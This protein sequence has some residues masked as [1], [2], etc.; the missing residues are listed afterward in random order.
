M[1]S[2]ITDPLSARPSPEE[3]AELQAAIPAEVRF[4]TST[5]TYPGW[6]GL[7]YSRPYPETGAAARMLAEYARWPL[8]GTVGIDS[9]FYGPPKPATL[10]AWAKALTPGFPC[11]SKV[12]DRITVHTFSGERDRTKSG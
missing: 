10:T 12:W 6:Y 3:L 2:R 4:G 1:E 8:F 7:V 11:V 5:W 9:S